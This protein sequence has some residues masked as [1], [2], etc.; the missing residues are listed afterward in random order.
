MKIALPCGSECE[1]DEQD[2]YLRDVFPH[3]RRH[4]SGYV[5]IT[6][7]IPTEWG[8]VR[9]DVWLARAIVKPVATMYVVDHVDRNPLNNKRSNLRLATRSQN[10]KNRGKDKNKTSKYFGVSKSKVCKSKPWVVF[11]RG[12]DGKRNRGLFA[13]EI[14]AAK[15]AD[16]ISKELFGE[17]APQNFS[18]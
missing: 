1:I 11:I 3:W 4:P 5:L 17:F 7:Y 6:R 10:A 14:E 16:K 15:H 9:Q 12:P 2:S 8:A 13:T 18:N